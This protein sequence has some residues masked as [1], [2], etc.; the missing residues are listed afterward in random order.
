MIDAQLAAMYNLPVGVYGAGG[1]QPPPGTN[2]QPGLPPSG[3]PFYQI[4]GVAGV[5]NWLIGAAA[6]LAMP[7]VG[8]LLIAFVVL[9][10]VAVVVI[11]GG[12]FGIG[13]VMGDDS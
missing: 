5:E 11:G 2:P 7:F 10:V 3:S 6:S 13:L 8:P 12:A 9:L 4:P 1:P